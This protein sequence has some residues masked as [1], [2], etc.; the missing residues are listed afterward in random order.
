[1]LNPYS[2]TMK[3]LVFGTGALGGF[4][5]GILSQ[6]YDVTIYGREGKMLPIQ[7]SG[8][9]ITGVTDIVVHPKT[10]YK[11]EDLK[12]LIFDLIILTV[13]SYDTESAME[14]IKEIIGEKSAVLSLQNGLDNEEII[15]KI[16]GKQRTIGGVTSHGLT[17][18]EPGHVRHAGEGETKIGE[19]DGQQSERIKEI[20]QVLS[21][22]GIETEISSNI[23]K[24][25]W[26]KGIVNAG[27]NP[28]TAL[29]RLQ[30][31]YLLKIPSLEKLLEKTCLE[32]IEAAKLE[33][34]DLSDCDTIEKTKM[35][36]SL[37]AENRSS[38]LQDIERGRKTEID[39]INGK[40]V[41]I[42]QKHGIETP[43]N[44]TLV[45]LIKGIEEGRFPSENIL[46]LQNTSPY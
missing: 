18:V 34:I 6:K 2:I 26:I 30:N 11:L 21:S 28:L 24:E 7:N 22:S 13:K 3:I 8:L 19:M 32:F 31:G 20:A 45:S 42:G 1:M 5:G 9:R 25:I 43:I 35:V 44:S 14:A 10:V 4:V 15:S 46:P 17:F 39:S 41:M 38:M 27:I 16:I 37:T 36:A 29:T 33:G 12:D 23:K 40:I